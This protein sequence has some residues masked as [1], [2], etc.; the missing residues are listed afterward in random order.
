MQLKRKF[1]ILAVPAVLAIAGGAIAVNAATT[2]TP[3]PA[4]SSQKDTGTEN[5]AGEV[6]TAGQAGEV[7]TANE[8]GDQGQN[9]HADTGD[10]VDHQSGANE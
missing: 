6:E 7:E 10:N 1:A 9:G 3:S 8:A 4:S 5:Q 2:P